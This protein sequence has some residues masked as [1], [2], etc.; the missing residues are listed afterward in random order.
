[1]TV[2]NRRNERDITCIGIDETR[3]VPA[4]PLVLLVGKGGRQLPRLPLSPH[5]R[6]RRLLRAQG[7]RA[8]RGRI[9]IA[10]V[11]GNIELGALAWQHGSRS[12]LNLG[13]R[14]AMLACLGQR[15]AA[16]GRYTWHWQG[17]ST[18]A[19]IGV[20]LPRAGSRDKQ[21]RR[22]VRTMGQTIA[23]ALGAYIESE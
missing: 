8:P 13:S 14:R 6:A 4:C 21:C 16:R 17:R 15:H 9:Q 11:T 7:K 2:A 22:E 1:D 19:M 5:R 12:V 3:R 23:E 10:N 20:S 18:L